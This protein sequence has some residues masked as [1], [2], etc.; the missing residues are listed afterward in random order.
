ML[1][2]NIFHNEKFQYINRRAL[3]YFRVKNIS[4]FNSRV[5]C[6]LFDFLS[7]I[8]SFG[9]NFTQITIKLEIRSQ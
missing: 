8:G 2:L 1:R 4:N 5:E 3:G 6:D 9:K 7:M